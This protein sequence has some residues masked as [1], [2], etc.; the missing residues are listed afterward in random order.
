MKTRIRSKPKWWSLL[1]ALAGAGIGYLL[2]ERSMLWAMLGANAGLQL[3]AA[4]DSL[5]AANRPVTAETGQHASL[6]ARP[7]KP[8]RRTFSLLALFAVTTALATVLAFARGSMVAL[9]LWVLLPLLTLA[10]G[11]WLSIRNLR[12]PVPSESPPV[13]QGD[14]R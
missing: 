4:W 1:G 14:Q 2:L 12:R 11:H 10:L 7:A 3:V 5:L 9:G 6:R 8:R 13:I